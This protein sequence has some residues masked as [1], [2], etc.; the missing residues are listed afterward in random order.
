M[1]AWACTAECKRNTN[2][3]CRK[4]GIASEHKRHIAVQHAGSV[5]PSSEPRNGKC[6]QRAF[7]T[8][9]RPCPDGPNAATTANVAVCPTPATAQPGA[10]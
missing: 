10:I 3:G 2:D 5:K 7:H 1:D 4:P 8:N 9:S 6:E